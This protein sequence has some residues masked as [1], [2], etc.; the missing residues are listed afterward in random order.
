LFGAISIIS[1]VLNYLLI[2]NIFNII[3]TVS[4][5]VLLSLLL[6]SVVSI[7]S[8]I[9]LIRGKEAI[10]HTYTIEW[11][12]K[13]ILLKYLPFYNIYLWYKN[14]NFEKPNRW[15][16]E[17]LI[18]W[19]IFTLIACFGSS[20]WSSI[21][22]MLIIIRVAS[23]MSDIDILSIKNK[24]RINKLFL[25]NPEE[26]RWYVVGFLSYLG[27]AIIHIF[28]PLQPYNLS[29]EIQKY[30]EQYSHILTL[31]NNNYL[32]LEYS[33]WI[34]LT[35]WIFYFILPDFTTRIYYVWFWLLVFRYSIMAIQLK[36]LP[37]L[38]IAK[39]ITILIKS[40]IQLFRPKS[41]ISNK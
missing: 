39:E 15:I 12:K 22:L 17:S 28:I 34:L 4:I 5:F 36:H 35:I 8:D 14:H 25:K 32:I 16:K 23:L 30:K 38:P 10:L 19:T 7:L 3:Y 6:I 31:K 20:I 37:H 9:S 11:N 33:I 1:W 24:Q 40:F 18:L 41:F 21:F 2:I 13:D 26:L 29:Y 27:K